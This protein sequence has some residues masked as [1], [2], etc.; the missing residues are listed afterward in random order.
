MKEIQDLSHVFIF[1]IGYNTHKHT[2]SLY[3]SLLLFRILYL[4]E[5]DSFYDFVFDIT[6]ILDFIIVL[7]LVSC[8]T[9]Q[10]YVLHIAKPSKRNYHYDF[11]TAQS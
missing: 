4:K 10:I 8:V 7:D 9:E 6:Y 11:F 5:I 2:L 3:L 1:C